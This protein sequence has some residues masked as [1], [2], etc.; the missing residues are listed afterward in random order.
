MTS[1]SQVRTG[2]AM[3]GAGVALACLLPRLPD[4]ARAVAASYAA[5]WPVDRPGL[6]VYVV[7]PDEDVERW[8]RAVLPLA[9]SAASWTGLM[10][11]AVSAVRRS[12]LPAPAAAALLGGAVAVGDSLLADLGERVKARAAEAAAARDAEGSELPA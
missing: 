6:Q 11:V 1:L 8:K 7:I 4:R 3:R 9:S 10:L 12:A 5:A 2:S